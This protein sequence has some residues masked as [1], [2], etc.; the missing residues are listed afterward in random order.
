MTTKADGAPNNEFSVRQVSEMLDLSPKQIRAVAAD[1]ILTPTIGARGKFLF[2]F[3]D[4]VLLR[5]VANLI[6][7]GVPPHKVRTAVAMLRDQLP[8]DALLTEV[9][10]DASGRSVVVR[11]DSTTWEPVSGQTILDLDVDAVTDRIASVVNVP[12]AGTDKRSAI[13]W[14][15]FAD[16]IESTDPIAAEAAYRRAIEIDSTFADAHL[17]LG[18]LLHA[19]GAVSDALKE[20]ESA[21]SIDWDDATTFYNIGVASQDLGELSDAIAAYER[22]IELA[23]HFA[24]ARYNLATLYEELGN[25]ALAVQ[26]LRAYKDITDGRP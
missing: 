21:K 20:Y 8:D 12:T 6:R 19:A 16:E 13:D 14:Y 17:N 24:D 7:S 18:R 23:P 15:V 9:S 11:V 1:G 3:Q 2:S 10:L 26:H 4:L 22:A 5:S 25:K